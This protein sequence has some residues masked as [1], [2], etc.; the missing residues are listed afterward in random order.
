VAEFGNKSDAD[1]PDVD[2][3]GWTY[4][5]S[6]N[7]IIYKDGMVVDELSNNGMIL[8]VYK[9]DDEVAF[10]R[11]SSEDGSEIAQWVCEI[12]DLRPLYHYG[13]FVQSYI[14][15]KGVTYYGW[16]FGYFLEK[17]CKDLRIYGTLTSDDGLYVV[18][19]QTYTVKN[20]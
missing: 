8:K 20:S 4:G 10:I 9:Q 3:T 2:I 15:Y 6:E 1:Y 12:N 19:S 18:I 11:T 14:D 16:Y 5:G 7:Y 13:M 17:D